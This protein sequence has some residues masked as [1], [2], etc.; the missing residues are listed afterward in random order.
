LRN[1]DLVQEYVHG[2]LYFGAI[3]WCVIPPLL[4]ARLSIGGTAVP[5]VPPPCLTSTAT[6]AVQSMAADDACG[7]AS[8]RPNLD[9]VHPSST[10]GRAL[11]EMGG[12]QSTLEIA[13]REALAVHG[14]KVGLS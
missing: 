8:P 13:R 14:N 10:A 9:M 3:H 7:P 4:P 6:P 2:L 5:V 11:T 1:I 12:R